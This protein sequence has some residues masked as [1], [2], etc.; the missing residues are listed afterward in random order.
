MGKNQL[1]FWSDDQWSIDEVNMQNKKSVKA[2]GN[3]DCIKVV[4]EMQ[5]QHKGWTYKIN[6]VAFAV[7]FTCQGKWKKKLC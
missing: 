6:V 5:G 7:Y 1:R 2:R 4:V 3:K